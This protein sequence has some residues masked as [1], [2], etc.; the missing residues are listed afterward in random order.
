MN[1]Y[2]HVIAVCL[3]TYK[4]GRGRWRS[5]NSFVEGSERIRECI[6]DLV[7][8]CTRVDAGWIGPPDQVW[9][10]SEDE[11]VGGYKPTDEDVSGLEVW[12]R[13]TMVWPI[14][15]VGV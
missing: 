4:E 6:D 5:C 2:V 10:V 9:V 13:G 7:L 8:A 1:K 12:R 15:D 14:Q 3:E 11:W